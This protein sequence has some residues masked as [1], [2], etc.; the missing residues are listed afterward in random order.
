MNFINIRNFK[1]II[2]YLYINFLPR[3][4][5]VKFSYIFDLDISRL[6]ANVGVRSE[7]Y[8]QAYKKPAVIK[9]GININRYLH[10]AFQK[11]L[12]RSKLI[13]ENWW[14]D[15]FLLVNLSDSPKF[16]KVNQSLIKRIET[17]NF[18]SI[19]YFEILDIYSLC[20]RLSLFELAYHIRQKALEKALKYTCSS[21]KNQSWKL[22]AKLSALIEIGDF[23]EFDRLFPM[24]NSRK[25]KE[26]YF[27]NFLRRVFGNSKSLSDKNFINKIDS[28][29]DHEFRKYVENKKITI[30]G[31]APVEKKDGFEIDN[32]EIVL[33]TNYKLGDPVIKGKK[34]NI[35]YFNLETAKH[36]DKD[37][38][39]EWP[40]NTTWIVGKAKNYMEMILKR[41]SS[42][43]VN[44]DHINLRTLKIVDSAL[45]NGSLSLIQNI[46][47][48]LSRYNPKKI[49]LY[50]F[51]VMLSKERISGYYTDVKNHDDL[52]LKMTKCFPGHDPATQFF[53]LKSFWKLGFI[54]GDDRFEEVMKMDTKD[55]MINMQKNYLDRNKKN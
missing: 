25:K 52:H 33:R 47:F 50:H 55:Y 54:Q 53:I 13:K 27:L 41:L 19:E 43:G 17:S 30:V 6:R 22:K 9:N 45:F 8:F 5:K 32:S 4:L 51:D 21:K 18:N 10:I 7:D 11:H 34:C 36:I 1:Q 24:L 42:D 23:N 26:K 31:P 44:I 37:G 39:F 40:S 3:F 35:N 38:C 49:Y 15:F 46:I 12:V 28:I 48:D 20:L 14:S 16:D 29:N 2:K